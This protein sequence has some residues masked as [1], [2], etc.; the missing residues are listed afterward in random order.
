MKKYPYDNLEYN[1][2]I[3]RKLA[4]ALVIKFLLQNNCL[5]EFVDAWKYEKRRNISTKE[6]IE[7]CVNVIYNSDMSLTDL[8]SSTIASFSWIR[9][10]SELGQKIVWHEINKKWFS[11][12]PNIHIK[13]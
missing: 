9:A 11:M 1:G 3:P 4:V 2:E 8:F 10:E 6:I 5:R 12:I 7:S 13:Q